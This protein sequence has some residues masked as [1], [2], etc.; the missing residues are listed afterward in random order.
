MNISSFQF[1][2]F[3]SFI[4]LSQNVIYAIKTVCRVVYRKM[5]YA[6]VNMT[7]QFSRN[8]I[9]SAHILQFQIFCITILRSWRSQILQICQNFDPQY[10]RLRSTSHYR[11]YIMKCE[12][13][14][15][16]SRQQCTFISCPLY[17]SQNYLWILAEFN[18]N[19]KAAHV[20]F[21]KN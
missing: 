15:L 1:Y 3:F 19:L 18:C 9:E 11:K 21:D 10:K 14:N 13:I 5:S 20:Y 16:D 2:L 6:I 17:G 8:L 7:A 4:S 12:L